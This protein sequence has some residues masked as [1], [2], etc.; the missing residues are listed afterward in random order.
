MNK[1]HAKEF[2]GII[3]YFNELPD[4]RSHVNRRHLLVDVI[5]I[6][7]CA[8]LANADGPVAIEEWAKANE[9]WLKKYLRLPH[10]IPSHDTIGRI[11]EVL[12][13]R[14][15]Q[16]CFAEWISSLGGERLD[17]A[18]GPKAHVAIDGKTMRRSH[19]RRNNL[20]ALHIVSAWATEQGISLGQIAT[21]EKS[22]EITAIP[23]LLDFMDIKDTIISIDAAGCQKNIASQIVDAGGDYVLALKSNQPTLFN[24]VEELFTDHLADDF[25]RIPVSHMEETGKGHGRTEQRL[26]YQL[27]V[28]KDLPGVDQ[29]KGLK[30]IGAAIR[31]YK[32]GNG[33]EKCD[34][35]YYISSLRRNG[36]Q[37][38]TAVRNHWA[39]ENTLHWSLDMVYREDESR[40]RKRNHAQNLSWLRRLTLGLIKRHP[41]KQSNVMKRRIAGWCPEFMLQI[42]T[43][44]GS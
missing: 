37:F 10:G 4:P 22:N 9:G 42:L 32:E 23:E 2:K 19:D 16:K 44:T 34:V 39:I 40:V 41:Y 15:F 1:I 8:V 35:R 5:V 3:T 7:V 38:A 31:I 14:T 13:P 24:A 30:T 27:T 21:E 6:C 17:Q 36:R 33:L 20:G 29:W 12:E 28:P 43:G 11:L 26:Y 18:M 25:D